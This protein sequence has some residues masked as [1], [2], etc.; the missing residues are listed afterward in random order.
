[1]SNE[2]GYQQSSA[3]SGAVPG[4][5]G[6]LE[7][8]FHMRLSREWDERFEKLFRQGGVAKWYSGVGSEATTVASAACLRRDDALLTIHRDSGAILRITLP[9]RTWFRDCCR[10]RTVTDVRRPGN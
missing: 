3:G 2:P 9:A 8:H 4:T 6:M 10:W 7:T 5:I 1:M